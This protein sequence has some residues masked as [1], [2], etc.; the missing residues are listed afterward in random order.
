MAK[1]TVDVNVDIQPGH[2]NSENE[3]VLFKALKTITHPDGFVMHS[4]PHRGSIAPLQDPEF[5]RGEINKHLASMGYPEISG[6]EGVAA[7]AATV[8][9]P[10]V[11]AKHQAIRDA[12]QVKAEAEAKAAAEAA[13]KQQ[14]DLVAAI[15][16][17]IKAEDA[18]ASQATPAA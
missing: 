15:R 11:K 5:V 1:L 3:H 8:H 7:H 4:E 16:A 10:E 18:A 17:Q 12:A 14:A 13:A 9:T 2:T 6:W